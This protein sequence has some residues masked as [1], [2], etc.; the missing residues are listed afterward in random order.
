M[1]LFDKVVSGTIAGAKGL[2]GAGAAFARA[3]P[4]G[5][6]MAS[7]AT[8]GAASSV[9]QGDNYN[10]TA[11]M[12]NLISG[13]AVGAGAGL[14]A[15]GLF[16]HTAARSAGRF[17]GIN[18]VRGAAS[19]ARMA[20]WNRSPLGRL[21]GT[22]AGSA[23]G[24]IGAG[25]RVGK[26]LIKHPELAFTGAVLAGGAYTL[27]GSFTTERELSSGF[28]TEGRDMQEVDSGAIS[29]RNFQNSASG[30]SFGLSA[31]RHG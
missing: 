3:T 13:A 12:R 7:G 27:G 29:R 4:A 1:A 22:S 20:A 18:Q 26:T 8:I 14:L 5:F 24:I 25:A 15:R 31:R 30:L 23:R 16:T 6:M 19:G 11:L 2:F 17:L 21:L 28:S 10:S 9:Y